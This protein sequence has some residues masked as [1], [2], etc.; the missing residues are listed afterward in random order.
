MS[1]WNSKRFKNLIRA[2]LSLKNERDMASFLRDLCTLEELEEM[3]N[4][5]E[6]AQLLAKGLSYREVARE[7]E[8]STSTVTR[9]AQWLEEGEGGY[10]KAL[11][12]I[13]R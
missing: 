9:I 3:S 5:W 8:I 12:K 6:A 7:V 4:R 2:I 1:N 11:G 13:K 10:Q